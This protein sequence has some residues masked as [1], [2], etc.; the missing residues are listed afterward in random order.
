[1]TPSPRAIRP[2]DMLSAVALLISL[3]LYLWPV[4]VAVQGAL[5]SNE[6]KFV[7]IAASSI[8]ND[9]DAGL[10]VSSNILS[11]GRH[12]P[13]VRYTSPD[14]L[15]A[16]DF[17]LPAAFTV[18]TAADSSKAAT[19]A[20]DAVPSLYGIVNSDGAWRAL[21]R[22]AESDAS[23]VLLREGERRGSYVVVSIRP[24]AV[25]VSGPSGQRTLRLNRASRN[26]STGKS[27]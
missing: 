23:P 12:A 20:P 10:V 27:L 16:P 19:D 26:D 3:G 2:L 8:A 6:Y 24:N 18:G 25:V 4:N 1:M 14:L 21:I 11:S 7:A 9:N 13:S 17:S 5:A 22:L 15:P